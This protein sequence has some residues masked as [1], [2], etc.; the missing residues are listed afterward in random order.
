MRADHQAWRTSSSGIVARSCNGR[1][2]RARRTRPGFTLAEMMTVF[3]VLGVLASVA[4]P[5]Y[6]QTRVKAQAA[7]VIADYGVIRLA[8]IQHFTQAG[9]Y[10]R[11]LGWTRVP[12]EFVDDLPAG[13]GFTHNQVDYRWRRWATPSG[14]LRGQNTPGLIGIE[15][16]T[17]D[18]VLLAEIRGRF[19]GTSFGSGN[20][21]TLVIE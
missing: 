6:N 17:A 4:M 21:L 11:S 8:A 5:M 12:A 16:R 13:F 1:A 18:R 3:V 14:L 20:R 7:S 9:S 2:V 19:G 10:P 15:L